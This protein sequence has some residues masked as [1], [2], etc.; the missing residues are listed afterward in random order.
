MKKTP[1]TSSKTVLRSQV[2]YPAHIRR[3]LETMERRAKAIES[4]GLSYE[5]TAARIK[6]FCTLPEDSAHVSFAQ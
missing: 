3:A 6:E 2:V 1:K 5:E 4:K